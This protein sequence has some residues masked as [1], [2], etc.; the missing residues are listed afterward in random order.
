MFLQLPGTTNSVELPG[1]IFLNQRGLFI[2]RPEIA[3]S[4]GPWLAFVAAGLLVA[5]GAR[6]VNARRA[7]SGR[8]A[9][10]IRLAR[11]APRSSRCP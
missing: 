5:V 7:A 4:L 3:A 11:G 1:S 8:V 6:L 10:A 9:L 2:P